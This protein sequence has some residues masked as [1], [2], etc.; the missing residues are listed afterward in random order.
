MRYQGLA[1]QRCCYTCDVLSGRASNVFSSSSSALVGVGSAG[2]SPHFSPH[3]HTCV[4]GAVRWASASTVACFSAASLSAASTATAF[5]DSRLSFTCGSSTKWTCKGGKRQLCSVRTMVSSRSH[6]ICLHFDL[7]GVMI[8][9]KVPIHILA[10]PIVV[11]H[12]HLRVLFTELLVRLEHILA[13]HESAHRMLSTIT[14][15]RRARQ[16]MSCGPAF[17]LTCRASKAECLARNASSCFASASI[18]SFIPS[19]PCVDRA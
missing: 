15:Q 17:Q 6:L 5:S 3:A 7:G 10:A 18:W 4:H 11:Q 9:K 8:L 16:P 12:W 14:T 2:F 1:L 19:F 13:A